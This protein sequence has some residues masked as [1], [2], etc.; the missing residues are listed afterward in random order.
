MLAC[1]SMLGMNMLESDLASLWAMQVQ[2]TEKALARA[3]SGG[4]K[5]ASE[6]S[7]ENGAQDLLRRS[8]PEGTTF[9]R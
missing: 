7:Q 5:E 4:G 9:S 1:I 2:A 8:L 6:H 3:Q